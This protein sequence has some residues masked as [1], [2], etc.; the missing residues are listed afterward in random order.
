[1]VG[2]APDFVRK[3]IRNEFGFSRDGRP[4]YEEVHD[5]LHVSAEPLSRLPGCP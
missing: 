1:M 5:T 4:V 2:A 3:F